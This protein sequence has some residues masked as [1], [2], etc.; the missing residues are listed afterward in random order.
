MSFGSIKEWEDYCFSTHKSYIGNEH[1]KKWIHEK[2]ILIFNFSNLKNKQ[3][4]LISS[5][6]ND[7]VKI[8]SLHFKILYGNTGRFKNIAHKTNSAELLKIILK[9]RKKSHKSH[10]S[11]FILNNPIKTKNYVIKDGEALTY[12]PEGI[13]IFS[14]DPKM[15]YNNRF[16]RCR[17]KHETLHLLGLNIH[18]EDTKV[19]GYT[20]EKCI[21]EYNAPTI[22]LC[23]K[24]K[25]AL[26]YFWRGIMHATKKQFIKN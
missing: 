4:N 14:F 11:V 20:N 15:R 22:K 9:E 5:G 10:A 3:L 1:F 17:A 25:T 12:V 16:L 23:R 6:M 24:C 26:T 19:K 2:E 13:T 8:A 18:H 21:M 7:A